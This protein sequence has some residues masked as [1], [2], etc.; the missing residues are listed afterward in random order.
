MLRLTKIVQRSLKLNYIAF[1]SKA[2]KYSVICGLGA[3]LLFVYR[4]Y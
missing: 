3:V 4:C 1:V 2:L